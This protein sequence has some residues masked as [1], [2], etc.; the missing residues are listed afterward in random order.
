MNVGRI[1]RE[2]FVA[3]LL[4]AAGVAVWFLLAD[5][6]A[7]RPLFTPAMLGGALF[8]GVH[9]P[10]QAQVAAPAVVAYTMVHI[11]AFVVVGMIGAAMALAVETFPPALFLVVFGLAIFEFG[12]FLV[13][14]LVARPL[15]GA[16][17]WWSVA[18]GNAL[19]IVLMTYYF[20]R[21]HPVMREKILANPLGEAMTQFT[22]ERIKQA[23]GPREPPK[24]P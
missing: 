19:A 24:N 1:V 16:L 22:L 11:A 9:D 2:G 20:W 8:W 7:G 18:L 4:G 3:G 14:A 21:T 13:L 15:L 6:I 23:Q 5:T 12:F 17:T 10:A